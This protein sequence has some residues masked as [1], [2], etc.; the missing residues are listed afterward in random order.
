MGLLIDTDVL[1]LADRGDLDEAEQVALAVPAAA[2][3]A[4]A[5]RLR[6]ASGVDARGR[7]Q[8]QPGGPSL[9]EITAVHVAPPRSCVRTVRLI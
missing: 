4:D 6:L 8:R 9:Q 5:R 3:Q 1:I 2:D 7:G